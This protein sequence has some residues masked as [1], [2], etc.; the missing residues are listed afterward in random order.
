MTK[1]F[2]ASL[3]FSYRPRDARFFVCAVAFCCLALLVP[4]RSH[5]QAL[6][7]INGTVIDASGSAI[8]D[9]K[10]TVTNTDTNVS[11]TATT[12]SAGTYYITDLVPGT[13]NVKVEKSGFKSFV[14][15]SVTVVGG[16]TSTANATLQVG[17][18]S[19]EVTISAPAV[20]LQTEQPEV[21]TTLTTTL[22]QE[23]P[24]LIGGDMRQIDNFIFLVPGVTGDS[25]S[26]RINGGVDEQTEVMF[27]GVPEAFSETAGFTSW[28]QPPYD[29]IKD[30]DV[31]TGTFSAQ[32]GLGQGVEQYHTKSGTNSLHGNGFLFYRDDKY[33]G[34]AGAFLD[35]NP[36]NA[37][38]I[39]EPNTNI[40]RDWGF[41][42]GGPVWVPKLYNGRNRTFWFFSLDKF[43]FAQGQ[44]PITLPTT[45]ELNGDFSSLVNPSTGA[46]IPIFVPISWASN[47][48][49]IP[50]G[51]NPGAAPGQQ[52]PGNVIPQ[53]CFSANAKAL[54]PLVPKPSVGFTTPGSE[55]SNYTPSYVP[56]QTDRD[57]MFNIDHDLTPKQALHFLYWRQYHYLPAGWT[58]NALNDSTWNYEP[59]YGIEPTYSYAISPN[60]VMTAGVL[61]VHQN[62]DFYQTAPPPGGSF[63]AV[64]PGPYGGSF[65]PGI[66]FGGGSWEPRSWGTNGWQ[67]SINHKYG[68]SVMNNWLW[69]HGRHT[70][71]F[72]VDIRKTWQ[73]D[74]E[75]QQ[76]AGAFG[77]SSETTADPNETTTFGS[78]P[79]TNTGNGFASFLLGDAA[80]AN[81]QFAGDT[82]LRNSYVA[83]YFQDDIKLTP[84]FTLN[85][86]LRWDLAF[87]FDN[88][89]KFNQLTFFDANTPNTGAISTTTGKPL[90]GGM[91]EIGTCQ[92]CVGWQNMDMSWTH[93]SPRVGFTYQLTPKTV[94][95]GGLSWYWLDT[96]AF[97]YGVNKTAVNFGNNLNGTIGVDALPNQVPG[98]GQWDGNPLVAPTS[99]PLT[100]AFLNTQFP[101]QLTRKVKQGYNEQFVLGVQ[102]ELPGNM[103]LSA[104]GIYAHDLHLP[105]ALNP[106]NALDY[107]FV[108]NTC[109]Q[110]PTEVFF[111]DCVLG[112]SWTSAPAQAL[113]QSAGFGTT[114]I[115]PGSCPANS[116][117]SGF[118]GGPYFAP[119]ATFGCD[120]GTNG[121][122]LRAFLPYPMFRGIT[123]NFE[124]A[125]AVKYSGLQ[126]SLQ[127]RTGS[128]LTFLIG[129]TLSKTLS[130]T[131]SGFSTFNFKGLNPKNP[132]AEWSIA[133]DDRHQV[134]TMA[135][136]YELPL[137]PGRK[138]LNHGGTL[139]RN[140]AGGWKLSMVNRYM[141]GT[142]LQVA[143][144]NG[145]FNGT[146]LAYTTQSNTPDFVSAGSFNVN[147]SG[148]NA[149]PCTALPCPAGT[150]ASFNPAKFTFP[151]A[152][153]IGNAAPLYTGLRHPGF[154]NEDLSLSKK[155]FFTEQFTG[156][157][158]VEFFNVFNRMT[159]GSCVDTNVGDP[160]FG[161][162]TQPG[163]PC[164]DNSPR[165][166]QLML[167]LSF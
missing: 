134:L 19:E 147:W 86:G 154:F 33:L 165:T 152:W 125:G 94:L 4:T 99:P 148:A 44:S 161:L 9:A 40:Q 124:T 103:F 30:V 133:N 29:S 117:S 38:V 95:L 70:M 101:H 110:G 66:N 85:A 139:M 122:T 131:D 109:T 58:T 18:V 113:L 52:F 31:L 46:P 119:Y 107:G 73:R 14:Q 65:L 87:P 143:S 83:P 28:N 159:A 35:I 157:L 156:E 135:G 25:F 108:Q 5:A 13:Y 57:W 37:G 164:Q 2:F 26:H 24:Q 76:C 1:G 146:P 100:S 11:R 105:S 112:Q 60:L 126:V 136:V 115:A 96:G 150:F 47:P 98:Y 64:Q 128:G 50:S 42:L 53:S 104:T 80:S 12:T 121:L 56:V 149:H 93:F 144:T 62:N 129:Y 88:D 151:G 41:S 71:N 39:G 43:R 74:Y 111:Q 20:A 140:V 7:G 49:L 127:K 153:T 163:V 79:G 16:A 114:T 22:T 102:R 137:G 155:F 72:G 90:L 68:L 166:G 3:G 130:N 17:T 145:T 77:F 48:S 23:L 132:Q 59:A 63:N 69:Q 27:N 81:R 141:S 160:N 21:G 32:Y 15:N 116:P 106:A 67:Y 120:Y 78:A 55:R 54:L 8:P 45:A 91:A 36:N 6:S 158:G 89:N 75:C 61:W 118:S 123:N 138:F 84:R 97:E 162:N 167:K 10:V 51:C 142:P 34:A 82:R 92:G